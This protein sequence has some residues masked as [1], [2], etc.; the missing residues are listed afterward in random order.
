[1]KIFL[2]LRWLVAAVAVILVITLLWLATTDNLSV[3]PI[4]N[5]LQYRALTWWWERTG[6]P[7]PGV[8]G[9]LRGMV[10]DSQ[11]QPVAG[12]WVLAAWWDGTT[13]SARSE[14]DGS[15]TIPDLPAGQ[16]RPVA[17]AP[18]YEDVQLGGWGWVTINAGAETVVDVTLPNELQ[19]TLTPGT[20]LTLGEP[21]EVSCPEPIEATVLRRQITF[22]S[23]GKPNQPAAYYTPITTT[24]TSQLP[25]LLTVYPGPVAY[26]EC[27]SLPLAAAGYAVVAVGPAY[28][29]ELE[30]DIDE[31]ERV[32]NFIR[33]GQFP[34]SDSSKLAILGGSYSGLHVQRILQRNPNFEAVVLLGPPTDLFD[35]RRRLE[36]RTFIPPFGLDQA[37]IALG[38][39]DRAPMRYWRY[40]G[41]YHIDPNLPPLVVM[42]SRTD[43]VVPFQQSE[44]LSANLAKVGVA[45]KTYFFD[46]ASH[47][48]LAEGGDTDTLEIYRI[49]L[50]FL[51]EHLK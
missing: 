39:P 49:T 47:Y 16:Y 2:P 30:S 36:D 7:N 20:N 23:G 12:A 6:F 25:V 10:R 19:G 32:V 26:W 8:P 41:A 15:F 5:T 51:A 35:M 17:G 22:E 46:G 9:T 1:M 24:A 44:L 43:E 31:L 11:G 40:S 48:L 42:H 29:L 4:R 37:M 33:A 14:A 18:G 13:Y 50:D 3:W 38:L 28:S 34:G 27:A 21:S 45:H